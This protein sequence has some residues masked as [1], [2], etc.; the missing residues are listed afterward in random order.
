MNED[1]KELGKRRLQELKD[2]VQGKIPFPDTK[3]LGVEEYLK[4]LDERKQNCIEAQFDKQTIELD[5]IAKR[6]PYAW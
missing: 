1:I 2:M 4:V 6:K 3:G 5:D